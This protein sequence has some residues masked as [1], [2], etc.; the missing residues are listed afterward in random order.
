MCKYRLTQRE[1]STPGLRTN[2]TLR[3]SHC[4]LVDYQSRELRIISQER[5]LALAVQ[6]RPRGRVGRAGLSVKGRST[7]S[8]PCTEVSAGPAE[9]GRGLKGGY[10]HGPRCT[11]HHALGVRPAISAGRPTGGHAVEPASW[12]SKDRSACVDSQCQCQC[13]VSTPSDSV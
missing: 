2:M 6:I 1:C 12:R 9:T 3:A 10:A 4:A 5:N 11:R 7:Q 13:C 8:D